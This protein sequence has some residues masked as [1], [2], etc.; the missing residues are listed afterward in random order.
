VLLLLKAGTDETFGARSTNST[1]GGIC[2]CGKGEGVKTGGATSV[3]L[4]SICGVDGTGVNSTRGVG[5]MPVLGSAVTKVGVTSSV[6]AIIGIIVAVGEA[7]GCAVKVGGMAWRVCK[8]AALSVAARFGVMVK[9][10]VGVKVFVGVRVLVAVAGG[11][12]VGVCDGLAVKVGLATMIKGV[13]LGGRV[14]VGLG[15]GVKLG[16]GVNVGVFVSVA[17]GVKVFVGVVVPVDVAVSVAVGRGVLV[18]GGVWLGDGVWLGVLLARIIGVRL[19][20]S[21]IRVA[22]G[23]FVAATVGVTSGKLVPQAAKLK[24][25]NNASSKR[26]PAIAIPLSAN[27]HFPYYNAVELIARLR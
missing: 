9:V 21:A 1:V 20:C 19:A 26:S 27:K 23:V 10:A 22:S 15:V 4:K 16:L 18:G 3:A 7:S 14:L 5:I 2:S 17:V 12:K 24:A 13:G 11:V 6:G 8:R 25:K